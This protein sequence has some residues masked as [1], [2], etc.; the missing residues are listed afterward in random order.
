MSYF[1]VKF[2]EILVKIQRKT[3]R[4]FREK[5]GKIFMKH[6]RISKCTWENNRN[7]DNNLIKIAKKFWGRLREDFQDIL[8]NFKQLGIN[9]TMVST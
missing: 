6:K 3:S 5:P 9:L 4:K 7:V 8:E 2:V 1:C